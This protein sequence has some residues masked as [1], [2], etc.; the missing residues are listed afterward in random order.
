M[1]RSIQRVCTLNNAG[2]QTKFECRL[3][4]A[5]AEPVCPHDRRD[6]HGEV[7]FR[8]R[9]NHWVIAQGDGFVGLA[10]KEDLDRGGSP[11]IAS[12]SSSINHDKRT[13]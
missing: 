9:C 11:A 13:G 4:L 12:T 6:E 3:Q 7:A 10:P 5:F 2:E 1:A 8:L